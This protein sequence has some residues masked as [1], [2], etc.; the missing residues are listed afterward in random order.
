M[1][2]SIWEKENSQDRMYFENSQEG[3]EESMQKLKA[4]YSDEIV[5][6]V[7]S[8]L[9]LEDIEKINEEL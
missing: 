4:Y 7:Q 5:D 9:F 6:V 8:L 3:I 1:L 2:S